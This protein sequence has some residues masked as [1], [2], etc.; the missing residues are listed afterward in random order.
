MWTATM[1]VAGLIV[2]A[3]LLTRP[4]TRPMTLRGAVIR[5]DADPTKELPLADVEIAGA[6]QWRRDRRGQVGCLRFFHGH[7]AHP[8]LDRPGGHAPLS[9]R[10]LPAAGPQGIRGR[11]VI[12][13]PHG[14]PAARSQARESSRD[15]GIECTGPLFDQDHQHRQ[16]GQR[17]QDL[18]SGEHRQRALPETA[19]LLARRAMEGC[20]GLGVARRRRRQ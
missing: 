8:A 7:V 4:H 15:H 1:V 3:I 14:A 18:R 16:R 10:R 19:A 2:T 12:R 9:A 20:D 11:Q 17:G 6:L 5:Q 13:G